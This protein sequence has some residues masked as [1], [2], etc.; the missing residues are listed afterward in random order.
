M[1]ALTP[2]VDSLD[3]V[4]EAARPFYEAK[5]G[6][7]HVSLEG[8]PAGFVPA[9]E[10]A[11]QLG[12]VVEF[13][14][15][16]IALLQ[17]VETLRPLKT[18]FEGIDPV[19][20]KTAIAA[21]A[22]LGKKGVKGADDLAAQITAAVTAAVAPLKSQLDTAVK[23][24]AAE[25]I[26]ADQSVLRSQVSEKFLKAGGKPN[27][28]DF[29]LGKA[30]ESFQVEGGAVKALPNK[31]SSDRPGDALGLDEWLVGAARENDFAF[32]T[33]GGTGAAPVKGSSNVRAGQTILRDP[34]PQQ[35][36]DAQVAKD[37]K[38]GKTRIEY[39]TK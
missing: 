21:Q 24:T 35:L 30:Q 16:N 34:T 18:Q 17:E 26:R 11:T 7:F 2:V 10:H 4:P 25:R 36:G 23:E 19:T 9:A 28:I 32:E 13:R 6:K 29:I 14:D 1:P 20:A 5:D 39:T 31:F 27:A 12:K 38:A 37:L 3:K 15:R 22:E 33:S 8:A